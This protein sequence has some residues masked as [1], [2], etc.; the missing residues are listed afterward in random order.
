MDYDA[1]PFIVVIVDEMANLMMVAG[2]DI[3][4]RSAASRADGARRGHSTSSPPRSAPSV[5][6]ITGTIKANFPT[7][8]LPGHLEDR[9]PHHSWRAG[10]RAA[11][12][13]G[14]HALYGGRRCIAACMVPSSPTRRSRRWSST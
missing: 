8:Q 1:M 3:E 6:V 4:S 5:D 2:K 11:A 10:R 12:R 7:G 14:R 9:Q 13:P